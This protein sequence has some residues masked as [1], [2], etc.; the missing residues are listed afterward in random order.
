MQRPQT[1][2][3]DPSRGIRVQAGALQSRLGPHDLVRQAGD[4]SNA[5]PGGTS[6][7][8]KQQQRR[9]HSCARSDCA[10]WRP[11]RDDADVS[12]GWDGWEAQT[13]AS[14]GSKQLI[15]VRKRTASRLITTEPA[16][17]PKHH[18]ATHL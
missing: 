1:L 13:D 15:F 18:L 8:L 12:N 7:P 3:N 9:F 11:S 17:Q 5:I 6:V 4:R 2:E 14:G 16:Q 10:G